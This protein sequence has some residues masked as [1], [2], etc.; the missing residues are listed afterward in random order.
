MSG[1][2]FPDLSQ[3]QG[4]A[5]VGRASAP[6]FAMSRALLQPRDVLCEHMNMR[7]PIHWGIGLFQKLDRTGSSK[8]STVHAGICSAGGD[9][10]RVAQSHGAGLTD[11]ALD[12]Q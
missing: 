5:A 4:S 6:C 1:F 9:A 10:S 2:L 7:A 11:D 3:V 12:G 8:S